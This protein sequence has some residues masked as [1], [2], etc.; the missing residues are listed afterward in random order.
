MQRHHRFVTYV[1]PLIAEWIRKQAEERR[2]SA[3]IVVCD[4]IFDA[5]QRATERLGIVAPRPMGGDDEA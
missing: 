1:T 2:V 5:W 4:C 3:S